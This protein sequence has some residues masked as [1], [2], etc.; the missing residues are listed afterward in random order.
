[1]LLS[2]LGSGRYATFNVSCDCRKNENISF[3]SA[4]VGGDKIERKCTF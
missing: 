1:M 4:L 3:L 2:N